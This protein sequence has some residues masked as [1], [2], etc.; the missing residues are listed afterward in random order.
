MQLEEELEVQQEQESG[1]QQTNA[2]S[3]EKDNSNF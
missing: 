2:I 3:E 1:M